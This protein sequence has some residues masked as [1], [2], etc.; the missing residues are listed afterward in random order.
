MKTT[1]SKFHYV[2]CGLPNVWLQG[3]VA[4]RETSDGA[5]FHI[6]QIREL[7]EAIGMALVQKASLLTPDEFRYLRAETGLSRRNLGQI[8]GVSPETIKKWESGENT[9]PKA[10]DAW[11]RNLYLLHIHHEEVRDLITRINQGERQE[12]DI[13]LSKTEFG[14]KDCA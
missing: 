3:G 9:I 5:V 2:A 7:H 14:W 13:C 8:L 12:L 4:Q 6:E 11:L 10:S 1:A